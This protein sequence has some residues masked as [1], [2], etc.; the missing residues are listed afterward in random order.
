MFD[1][2]FVQRS[3]FASVAEMLLC[4]HAPVSGVMAFH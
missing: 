2:W 3:I 4:S 1:D